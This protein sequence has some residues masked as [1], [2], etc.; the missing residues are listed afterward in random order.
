M[1]TIRHSLVTAI[2]LLITGVAIGALST[3][4]GEGQ[5]RVPPTRETRRFYLTRT[6]HD[7]NEALTAC[8]SGYH[9]ASLWEIFD[10]TQLRY[11]TALGLVEDDSGAGPPVGFGYVRTGRDA[12]SASTP[13]GIPPNC[14]AWTSDNGALHEGVAVS[15]TFGW[16]FTAATSLS[17]WLA[18]VNVCSDPAHVWCVQD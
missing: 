10:P 1:T 16:Q 9:M 4:A 14:N 15:L 3:T 17:P 7:G 8:A 6:A 5:G 2:P 13:S 12:T 11:D 18:S